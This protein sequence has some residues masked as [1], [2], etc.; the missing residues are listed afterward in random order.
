MIIPMPIFLQS[1]N[2]EPLI[3]PH[4]LAVFGTIMIVA[5][6]ISIIG[7]LIHIGLSVVFDIETEILFRLASGG[8]FVS[9]VA[10][11]IF[12]ILLL[13]FGKTG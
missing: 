5:F 1:G 9:A 6:F 12:V 11:I 3:V 10:F 2:S 8:F 13:F 4:W 7:L